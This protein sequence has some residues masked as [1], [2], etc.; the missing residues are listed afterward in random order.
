M[1]NKEHL[2]ML[3]QDINTW[4]DWRKS[5]SKMRPD[6]SGANLSSIN[7]RGVDLSKANLRD[8]DFSWT[9]LG[10]ANLSEAN[11]SGSAFNKANLRESNLRKATLRGANFFEADLSEADLSGSNL[12]ETKFMEASLNGANITNADLGEADLRLANLFDT[13]FSKANLNKANLSGSDLDGANFSQANL[14]DSILSAVQ[15]LATNFSEATLTGACIE[16]WNTNGATNLDKVICDYIYLEDEQQ[17]RCP[18]DPNKCFSSGEFTQLFQ[19]ALETVVLFFRNGIDWQAFSQS[20]RSLQI[21]AGTEELSIQA[22]ESKENGSFVVRLNTPPGIDKAEIQRFIEQ[23]YANKLKIIED[24]YRV[25]LQAKDDQL[26]TFRHENTNLWEMAKLMATRTINIPVNLENKAISGNQYDMNRSQFSGGFSETVCGHQIGGVQFNF[27]P[28]QKQTL[29]EVIIDIQKL[30]TQLESQGMSP[31]QAQ[32]LLAKNMGVKAR[33][34]FSILSN[35]T[36][37]IASL[38]VENLEVEMKEPIK[39]VLKMA[40]SFAG[41]CSL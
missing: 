27:N 26:E 2:S 6:L 41:G 40:L 8:A 9:D 25:K 17:E 15:A 39:A 14:S 38:E 33:G 16:D 13:D 21:K 24:A 12:R 22:I 35:L 4:N 23:E 34:N 18:H 20:F 5:N 32:Q 10:R 36:D 37:W 19:K 29:S 7:L 30:L 1:V 11:L 28:E 31:T 3:K